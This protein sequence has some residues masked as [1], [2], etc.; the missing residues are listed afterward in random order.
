MITEL[1]ISNFKQL[2]NIELNN[3][4]QISIIGG[5]NNTG[6]TTLLEALFM[7]YDRAN[8]EVTIRPFRWRGVDQIDMSPSGIW[9]PIFYAYDMS[10]PINIAVKKEGNICEKLNISHNEKFDGVVKV[11]PSEQNIQQTQTTLKRHQTESLDFEYLE[12]CEYVGKS[13]CIIDGPQISIHLEDTITSKYNVTYVSSGIQRNPNEDAVRFGKIDIAGRVDEVVS[14]LRMIEPR[15]KSLSTIAHGNQSLIYGDIGIGRKI[16]LSFMG[17]GTA[18]M[19]SIILAIVTNDK[20]LVLIDELENGIHHSVHSKLWNLLETLSLRYNCQIIATTHSYEILK[21]L[22]D[23]T[24]NKKEIFSY[25][26]LSNS[27]GDISA[28]HYNVDTLFAAI[29]SELEIR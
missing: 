9:A 28:N 10:K 19:L 26:R 15:L 5:K 8:P 1:K 22:K 17:E 27:E 25:F 12:G 11:N 18:K 4:T 13:H 14:S 23:S 24:N 20:G 7:F 16:P 29:E 6:K 3:I 2:K 21:S